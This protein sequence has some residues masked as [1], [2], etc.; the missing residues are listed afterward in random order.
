[1][2]SASRDRSP[3]APPRV[4]IVVL[5]WR[6]LEASR[7]CLR[8]LRD[9]TYPAATVYLLD[10]GS[11]DG[12]MEALEQ[13]F[14][15]GREILLRNGENL[16]FAAGCNRGIARALADGCDYVLLLNNDCVLWDPGFLEAGIARA[17]RSPSIG[18]VGGKIRRWPDDGRLWSTGGRLSFWGEEVHVG[19]G[20][21]DRGQY[22]EAAPRTFI[23]GALMLIRRAVI[24]AIGPLPEAYFFGKEEWEY[25]TRARRAGFELWYE[26][27]FRI[28]HEAGDSHEWTDPTYVYNGTLSKILYK[29]RNLPAPAFAL[30]WTVFRL[31]LAVLFPLRYAL[32]KRAFLGGVPPRVIRAAMRRAAREAPGC[33][34]VTREM[35]E[36]FRRESGLVTPPPSAAR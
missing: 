14:A 2:S 19:H 34:Q 5:N 4:G 8:S 11:G 29:R 18:I 26:P 16:G 12:S 6:N 17:E 22:E 20:E 30:W 36:R 1:M 21:P 3:G 24:E 28:H 33:E 7:R 13:E 9:M 31:Y 15:G 10:N 25:S 32:Q 23:S 27:A 35:L